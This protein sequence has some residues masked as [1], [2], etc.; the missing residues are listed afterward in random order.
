MNASVKIDWLNIALML[1]S[2]ALA[3]VLPFELFLFS[4]AILGP[5]HYLTEIS[6][7]KEKYFFTTQKH[8]WV[9]LALVAFIITISIFSNADA[10]IH[11]FN[12]VFVA[13]TFSVVLLLTSSL[14][15]RLTAFIG[16]LIISSVFKSSFELVF[17]VFI[18]TI[19]HVYIFTGLFMLY[20]ALK[21]KSKPGYIG[22][23]LLVACAFILLNLDLPYQNILNWEYI[24]KSYIDFQVLNIELISLFD[25]SASTDRG[26]ELY[27]SQIGWKI[28]R[29]IA[30]AYT[31][32]YLNWF[33]KTS[34]IRWHKVAKPYIYISAFIWI[35]S[36]GLYLFDYRIGL[37]W[38][39]FL[40]FLHVLLEFPLNIVSVKGIYSESVSIF[41]NKKNCIK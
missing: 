38:L 32:H 16:I 12:W 20:G 30:F 28:M 39:F 2:L 14:N 37:R 18:P 33:S 1:I 27:H 34:I 22:V 8:D 29:F 3:F 10:W 21:S 13:F 19:L 25:N 41:R 4:Y 17:A 5:L 24:K 7:L 31:Y 6:W 11:A 26:Y 9:W 36:I 15:V 35:A 23:G 40:S